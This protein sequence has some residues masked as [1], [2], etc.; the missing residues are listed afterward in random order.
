VNFA[1]NGANML[2]IRQIVFVVR[3][4]AMTSRRLAELLALDPPYRDP[5]VAEFGIDNAVFAFGDQFIELIS[6]VQG[7]TAAGRH[8]ERRGEGGYML[9]L[10]T[11]DFDRDCARVRALG[12]RTVWEKSLPD[13][14][15]MHLHPKDIGGAIVSIDQPVPVASWRW[16]G[17]WRQQHG[18]RGEQRVV[19][20]TVEAGRPREMAQRWAQVLG[21]D[22]VPATDADRIALSD[23]SI[24]FVQAT[25]RGEGIAGWTWRVADPASVL[26]TAR[27]QGVAV[28]GDC[29]ALFGATVT[30]TPR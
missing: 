7:G 14:R 19:A 11:D 29:I 3:D 20:V 15:A 9:I 6:P 26:R 17:P 24:E 23:G 22:A 21:V 10:Q 8:L 25:A 4:L 2:R 28:G 5:G 1:S 30:L 16:G 18:R 12:V 27:E 13:I